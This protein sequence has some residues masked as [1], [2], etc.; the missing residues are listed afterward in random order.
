MI[1][2]AY[3][4]QVRMSATDQIEQAGSAL[5]PSPSASAGPETRPARRSRPPKCRGA[6]AAGLRGTE[7][8]RWRRGRWRRQGGGEVE[9]ADPPKPRTARHGGEGG[10]RP[11]RGPA[12]LLPRLCGGPGMAG[13]GVRRGRGGHGRQNLA[14]QAP[15]HR[16]GGNR[17]RHRQRSP[18]RRG[19]GWTG[20]KWVRADGVDMYLG[21]SKEAVSLSRGSPSKTAREAPS[22]RTPTWKDSG[23]AEQGCTKSATGGTSAA[24]W[25]RSL[26]GGRPYH[27]VTEA[28]RVH[29]GLALRAPDGR[30]ERA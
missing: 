19:G 12:R 23:L 10:R 18:R 30:S 14:D 24:R 21:S 7:G 5:A 1:W 13:P 3:K 27:R 9:E 28:Q 26:N 8:R 29:P 15:Q 16:R 22:A 6:R 4:P 11:Q 20:S 25:T 2:I 17:G